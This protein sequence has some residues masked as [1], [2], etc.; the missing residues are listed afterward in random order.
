MSEGLFFPQQVGSTQSSTSQNS[1]L[2]NSFQD[3]SLPATEN[4]GLSSTISTNPMGAY[5]A[6]D[7]SSKYFVKTL[8]VKDMVLQEDRSLW[9]NGGRT[10]NVQFTQDFSGVVAFAAGSI[11]L[12]NSIN[13][14]TVKLNGTA[15]SFSVSGNILRASFIIKPKVIGIPASIPYLVDNAITTTVQYTGFSDEDGGTVIGS[16]GAYNFINDQNKYFLVD[17]GST[18]SNDIHTYTIKSIGDATAADESVEILGVVLYMSSDPVNVHVNPGNTY[19]N[20]NLVSTNTG[21]SLAL[22]ALGSS[23]F[24]LG[25]KTTYYK[26]SGGT[27][28]ASTYQV[29]L[30][31]TVATG[32]SGQNTLTVSTGTGA[33]YPKGTGV[34]IQAGTS[35]IYQI[36]TARSTDTLTVSASHPFTFTS[37]TLTKSFF[38][39]TG[40]SFPLGYTLAV[41]GSSQYYLAYSWNAAQT[42]GASSWASNQVIFPNAGG[43]GFQGYTAINGT[44]TAFGTSLMPYQAYYDPENRYAIL[45]YV[46]VTQ[47]GM[48]Q[49]NGIFG[50]QGLLGVRGDFQAIELE[51]YI[52][53]S[54][55]NFAAAIDGLEAD[56]SG[57]INSATLPNYNRF[58][59][60][61]DLGIGNHSVNLDFT[62]GGASR[63]VLT[64]INFYKYIGNSLQGKLSSV[65]QLQT[66]VPTY[67]GNVTFPGQYLPFAGEH[68]FYGADKLTFAGS[69]IKNRAGGVGA[70][71]SFTP[72]FAECVGNSTNSTC[73]FKYWGNTFAA[74]LSSNG[75]SYISTLDG[76]SIGVVSGALNAGGSLA[77]HTLVFTFKSGTFGIQGVG[78]YRPYNELKCEQKFVPIQELTEIDGTLIKEK[79]VSV[80]RARQRQVGVSMGIGGIALSPLIGISLLG[81]AGTT[82]LTSIYLE[83]SGNPVLYGFCNFGDVTVP[84]GMVLNGEPNFIFTAVVNVTL[85][86]MVNFIPA[87]LPMGVPEEAA[88]GTPIGV[89]IVGKITN[90]LY[91]FPSVGTAAGTSGTI[92][93]M[94]LAGLKDLDL[95]PAGRW[96]YQMHAGVA[97]AVGVG[98]IQ[99]TRFFAMELF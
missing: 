86:G 25:A 63:A 85:P 8:W 1:Y 78:I 71:L 51:Y 13:G 24:H 66:T 6:D 35:F 83:T 92:T 7:D 84:G 74:Y 54:M 37:A 55:I 45:P 21:V 23:F 50:W 40:G 34:V 73:T 15:S 89:S 30:L 68:S 90:H 77:E 58:T 43:T 36:V 12:N 46:G 99:F 38:A 95:V 59:Y 29:P 42:Y 26:T 18:Q 2:N 52:S 49:V 39:F 20:K 9:F 70:S 44:T 48:A 22:P 93:K 69:W 61:K 10:Y 4:V 97:S 3:Y 33:S 96:Q 53:T 98:Q 87:R 16:L 19:I 64:G 60:V 91:Q 67:N 14:K 28:T 17:D 11:S 82:L 75:G 32:L 88:I 56:I 5:F 79:S 76:L 62:T 47:G 27:D 94:P 31:Q 80:R 81:G 41:A 65:E 57:A 72:G